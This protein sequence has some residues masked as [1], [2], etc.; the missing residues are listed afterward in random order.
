MGVTPVLFDTKSRGRE[1]FAVPLWPGCPV[2][3]LPA[4][5][6]PGRTTREIRLI[7]PAP[8]SLALMSEVAAYGTAVTAEP[9]PPPA[10]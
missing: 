8:G 5:T 7:A 3:R 9:Y 4:G 6:H 1:P 10:S 2:A